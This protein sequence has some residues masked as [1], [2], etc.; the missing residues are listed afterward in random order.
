MPQIIYVVLIIFSHALQL[1]WPNLCINSLCQ[2]SKNISESL[3]HF[4][5]A[6]VR[7]RLLHLIIS[8]PSTKLTLKARCT[9]MKMVSNKRWTTSIH[10]LIPQR[11]VS[12]YTSTLILNLHQS[13]TVIIQASWIPVTELR[14]RYSVRSSNRPV[15]E[16]Q[17]CIHSLHASLWLGGLTRNHSPQ[18]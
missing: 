1:K 2:I 10:L 11:Y 15:L 18:K 13:A 6:G 17:E 4:I 14:W 3:N 5:F 16:R 7:L 8:V 12:K 9:P